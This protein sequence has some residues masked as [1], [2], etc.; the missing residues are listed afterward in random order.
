MNHHV[1]DRRFGIDQLLRDEPTDLDMILNRTDKTFASIPAHLITLD[2]YSE[3]FGIY[4]HSTQ[5]QSPYAMVCLH[6]AEDTSLVDSFD[7]WLERYMA[8]NV[9]K[10]TG[11]SFNDFMHLTRDRADAILSRCEV[12]AEKEDNV[13][14]DALDSIDMRNKVRNDTRSR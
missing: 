9:L 6:E 14:G 7:V 3:Y 11:I 8:A 1:A 2:S 13:V 12:L 5:G 4:E 10:Y